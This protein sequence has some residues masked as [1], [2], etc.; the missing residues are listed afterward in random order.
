M[1]N[2]LKHSF[3]QAFSV[4]ILLSTFNLYSQSEINNPKSSISNLASGIDELINDS[5]FDKTLIAL[6]IFDLTD[7]ISLYQ[8]N[9][10]LL[11]RPASNMKLLSSAAALLHLGEYYSFR[12]DL[13]HTGVIEAD[14]LYGDIYVVGGFDPVFTTEDLDSL[15][16]IIKSLGIKHIA[17]DVYADISKKD[18]M[19]WGKGWMWDDDPEPSAPYLSA[20]NINGNSIEVF[21]EGSEIGSPA[22]VILNPQTDYAEVKNNSITVD[23][24]NSCDFLITRDWVN[25]KNTILLNGKV[26]IAEVI[27]SFEPD[28][29]V[30]LLYP[31]RYF[32]T[33]FKE[34]L[35]KREIFIGKSINIKM[36]AD[37]SVYLNTIYRPIGDSTFGG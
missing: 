28:S 14:T 36:L 2:I 33:L 32:L 20:L 10:K 26:S 6:D 16:S 3:K 34:H 12:T 13:F 7:S 19:Y 22:N 15:V 21:I 11:L 9:N 17:G 8:K 37:N 5:Y 1:K 24:N 35:E 25:R 23:E 30:N 27:N 4:V 29:K 31:E 18:S